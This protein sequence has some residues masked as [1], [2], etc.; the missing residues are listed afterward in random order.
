MSRIKIDKVLFEDILER[1]SVHNVFLVIE[2]ENPTEKK[3]YVK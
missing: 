3:W 2:K 1:R